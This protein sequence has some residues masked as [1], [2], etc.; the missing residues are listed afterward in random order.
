[1][2]TG[3]VAACV[4]AASG[5]SI[6]PEDG[7]AGAGLA[8]SWAE[9][10]AN[11]AREGGAVS[12]DGGRGRGKGD[13]LADF[14]ALNEEVRCAGE[15]MRDLSACGGASGDV[16]VVDVDFDLAAELTR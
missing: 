16:E 1:M 3:A 2:A 13:A 7:G 4:A 15:A 6:D 12:D 9:R 11:M 14:N 5:E 10:G 8:A